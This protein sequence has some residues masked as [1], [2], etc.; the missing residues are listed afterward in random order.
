MD[1]DP[2]HHRYF[3]ARRGEVLQQISDEYG[4]VSVSFPQNGSS[5]SRVKL[6]GA[7]DCV[8]KA[9]ERLLEIVY[10]LVSSVV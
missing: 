10:D 3:V 1:I 7:K 6:S 4:G 9:K 2:K 8:E 5:S